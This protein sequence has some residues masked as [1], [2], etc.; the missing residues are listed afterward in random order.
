MSTTTSL[1]THW[2]IPKQLRIPHTH[3]IPQESPKKPWVPLQTPK[4]TSESTWGHLRMTQNPPED[5]RDFFPKD[6]WESLW[7]SLGEPRE[8][9]WGHWASSWRSLRKPQKL[10]DPWESPWGPLRIILRTPED[11]S[12]STWRYTRIPENPLRTLRESPRGPLRIH[13]DLW[14]SLRIPL[15]PMIIPMRNSETISKFPEITE[16]PPRT[17]EN[18]WGHLK[19]PRRALRT[20]EKPEESL[21]PLRSPE[22]VWGP[23]RISNNP[24][25]PE[26]IPLRNPENT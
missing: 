22:D 15:R 1:Q 4:D 20:T 24:R 11:P 19:S 16:I 6:S 26:E 23:F 21:E 13:K 3:P 18:P 10:E 17:E 7:R 14:R 25:G 12:K 5:L 8:S 2:K 9:P